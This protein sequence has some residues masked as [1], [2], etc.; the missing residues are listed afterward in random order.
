VSFETPAA[1]WGLLSIALLVIFSLWRQA[2]AR[3]VVPSV[4]LWKKIPERNPP[5]RA[6]RRPRWRLDLLLQAL[7][8]A[9]AVAA[10]AGPFTLSA[11]PR[12]RKVAFVIDTSARM[13]AGGRLDRAKEEVRRLVETRL[14]DDE[15]SVFAAAPEPRRVALGELANLEAVHGHVDVGPLLEAARHEATH[16]VLISDRAPAGVRSMLLGGPAGNIGITE[17]TVTDADVFVRGVNHGPARGLTVRWRLDETGREERIEVPS[18]VWTWHRPVEAGKA[19][20]VSVEV[21]PSDAFPLD[22]HAHAFR[23]GPALTVVSVTGR[24]SPALLRALGSIPGVVVRQDGGEGT[25]AVGFDEVPAR[26]RLRVWLHSP[27]RPVRAPVRVEGHPLTA[28]LSDRGAELGEAGVGELPAAYRRG[29]A[30]FLAEG[31]AVGVVRDGE[32]HLGFDMDPNEGWPAGRPS[33]PIFWANVIDFAR[34]GAAGWTVFRTGRPV[35][36]PAEARVVDPSGRASGPTRVFLA[37]TVGEYRLRGAEGERPVRTCLLDGRESD[38][39][40]TSR[41]LDWDPGDPAEREPRR[42]SLG[43]LLSGAALAFVLLAWLLQRRGE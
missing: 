3:T 7:A 17:L 24:N 16:V 34:E 5:L 20:R 28:G 4:L 9:A 19:G 6:L 37:H 42:R 15:V 25:V 31:V 30:I 40:G 27:A 33:F 21:A 18:G 11:R 2:A 29:Q 10:L 35:E 32:V 43:G 23:L 41:A 39:A 22:D 38:V 36:L 8:V 14:A 26:G 13:L 1:F 12:P